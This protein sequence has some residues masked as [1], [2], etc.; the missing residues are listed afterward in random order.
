MEAAVIAEDWSEAGGGSRVQGRQRLH[1]SS[2]KN[3]I[4]IIAND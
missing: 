2:R 1:N 3:E 4:I